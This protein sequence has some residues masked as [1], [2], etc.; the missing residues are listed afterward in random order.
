MAIVADKKFWALEPDQVFRELGS[1]PVG[2]TTEEAEERLRSGKNIIERSSRAG[3]LKILLSQFKSPLILILVFASVVTA[4][5]KDYEDSAFILVAVLV[6]VGLGFYQ[7]NKAES[8]LEKLKTYIKERTR[9]VRSERDIEIEAAEIVPGDVIKLQPGSRVPADARVFKA[10]GISVDEAILTGESLAVAKSV[11]SVEEDADL[12]DRTSMVFG[13]TLIVD[14]KGLAIVTST[15][16]DTELGK[17]A[18]LVEGDTDQSTPLQKSISRFALV[19]GVAL[20][21]LSSLLFGLGV[22]LGFDLLEMFLTSVAIA[23][24]A[25]PEGL[26]IAMTVILAVGVER[27]ARRKGVV[28]KLLAAEALGS[29]TM[30]L[31]DKTGT[32]TEARMELSEIISER[33]KELILELALLNTDVVVGNPSGSPAQ[34]HI[35]GRPLDVAIAQAGIEHK[36]L[37]P[38]VFKKN[39]VVEYKPF[40]SRDKYSGVHAKIGNRSRWIYLGAPDVLLDMVKISEEEK[41]KTL[42]KIDELAFAGS[43]VLGLTV[44]NKFAGLLSFRDPVRKDVARAIREVGQAGVR[45]VVVTGD[46]KGTAMAVAN[47]VGLDVSK[48]EILTGKEIEKMSDKELDGYL[49]K[50]KV[51]ARVSPKDKL[52]LTNLYQKRGEIVAVTGDGVNDAPALKG[53]D[54]GV[55]VGSGTDVAKGAADLV[56][57]DDN[58]GTIVEAI[59]EGRR[60]VDNIRKV[61]VYL[62][63]SVLDELILIGG[64]LVMGVALPLNALQ[65]LWVNFFSDSF[66]AVGL[67]FEKGG[68][69][70]KNKPRRSGQGLMDGEMKFL[71]WGIGTATSLFLFGLYV[72]LLNL[73]FEGELVRTFIFASFS[74]YTLFLIFSIKSLDRSIFTY[75]P[76]DNPYLIAGSAFGIVLTAA[77]LYW[78]PLR[79][80]LGTVAL[81]PSWLWGV[82][83]V[84][85]I[86]ILLVEF[87][88]WLFTGK[89]R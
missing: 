60:I 44:D 39:E 19:M 56:I 68:D 30:V 4:F 2:L 75:N 7:E 63:S 85:M 66:P 45:T 40:N 50:T 86:N 76:F 16:E 79:G 42:L 61:I 12:G 55:A 78:A 84:G 8:A 49:Y 62:L 48:H 51:F 77:A 10:N 26:P 1:A 70:L 57:L 65:I 21:G 73:G 13:G 31:T 6:N 5:L 23:I 33:P 82:L 81:P 20:I 24:A 25:V 35:S 58:F 41:E 15:G 71:I 14:G 88:K 34:W 46:H 74:V 52:R 37:L 22:F 69:Y 38:D 27:L 18:A 11:V 72:Y 87:G 89:N 67:A 9:V 59:R 83:G 47:E 43:R 17:I 28:R 53:A 54:V 32:L 36:V 64:A 29:T 3:R 80:I